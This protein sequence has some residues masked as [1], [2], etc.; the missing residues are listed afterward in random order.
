MKFL[1]AFVNYSRNERR[2]LIVLVIILLILIVIRVLLPVVHTDNDIFEERIKIVTVKSQKNKLGNKVSSEEVSVDSGKSKPTF[3]VFDPNTVNY[4][5]LKKLG[6]SSFNANTIIKYRQSGGK[7]AKADDLYTI[8]GIDSALVSLLHNF[9]EINNNSNI[10]LNIK[11]SSSILP[12]LTDKNTIELN[13]ADTNQLKSLPGIGS[14]FSNRIIKYRNLL[15]GYVRIDQL[16]EVYGISD[17]TYTFIQHNFYIDSSSVQKMKLN[18]AEYNELLRHPYLQSKHV[19]AIIQYR[20]LIGDFKSPNQLVINH[21]LT[22]SELEKI[23]PY[24]TIEN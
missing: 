3:F 9:I 6:F 11:D 2:G 10:A 13:S 5:S 24:L 18:K 8:Y 19:K 1:L 21:L 20:K 4:H 15:G 12:I 22:K 17:E 16:K 23:K 7:F 14:V